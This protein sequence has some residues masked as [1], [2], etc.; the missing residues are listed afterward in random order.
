MMAMIDLCGFGKRRLGIN[1]VK[2][3][4]ED[5][6]H[7][8]LG[9]FGGVVKKYFAP[10]R[11]SRVLHSN[12]HSS[13]HNYYPQHVAESRKRKWLVLHLPPSF[14]HIGSGESM[15]FSSD[16]TSK[17]LGQAHCLPMKVKAFLITIYD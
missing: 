11:E 8:I 10:P 9:Q 15:P 13:G 6:N 1:Q 14:S 4:G 5:T 3:L 7:T 17:C 2:C 16:K 12:G